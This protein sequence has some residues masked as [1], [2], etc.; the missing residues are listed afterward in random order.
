MQRSKAEKKQTSKKKVS[1][2]KEYEYTIHLSP[3][4]N[5]PGRDTSARPE[6]GAIPYA[7]ADPANCGSAAP[8][9]GPGESLAV[10]A[11]AMV[12]M[13]FEFK[14]RLTG[15]CRPEGSSTKLK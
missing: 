12:S 1:A 15:G 11:G 14:L 6:A 9:T 2:S 4:P 10:A 3:S 7:L 5:S 8:S 13:M